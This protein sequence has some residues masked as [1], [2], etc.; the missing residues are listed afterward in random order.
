MAATKVTVRWDKMTLKDLEVD[1]SEPVELFRTQ[2]WTL[3]GVP[4]DRQTLI[5][6]GKKLKDEDSWENIRLR[7][8]SV[9]MMMG[10][11][12]QIPEA[13]KEKV[14]FVEDMEAE[15]SED[16]EHYQMVKRGLTNMGNTCYMNSTVQCL[17]QVDE[18]RGF[19][20]PLKEQSSS[21]DVR[22]KLGQSLDQLLERLDPEA[23][24]PLSFRP[25][26]FF[27]VL[28]QVH[29]A[30]GELQQGAVYKQQDA[31]ECWSLVLSQLAMA[32]SKDKNGE[33]PIDRLFGITMEETCTNTEGTDEV[34]QTNRVDR[35]LRCHIGNKTSH[36]YEGL[37]DG[38]EEE[39]TRN[40]QALGRDAL[41]KQTN[42]IKTLPP[43]L[44][45]H[46]VRFRW[47]P[48]ERVKAKILRSVSFPFTLDVL[49][50]CSDDLQ[51]QLK[52]K[53][54]DARKRRDGEIERITS[55]KGKQ[56]GDVNV[57]MQAKPSGSAQT[58]AAGAS[59]GSNAAK[60][61][62]GNEKGDVGPPLV[63]NAEI[64]VYELI[65]VLT[66]Q[67]RIAESGHYISYCKDSKDGT[68]Y[69][70]D[71]DRV[72]PQQ[73]DDI[74]KLT[75]GGDWHIAYMCLYRARNSFD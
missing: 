21:N 5:V 70:F 66:H 45:I 8:N 34:I 27:R 10:S 56:D 44:G 35:L 74:R 37:K 49:D 4:P 41:W 51:V 30:F 71:D 24:S 25:E 39:I 26:A 40:S 29:P 42:R 18:L 63:V 12:A 1:V 54:E 32:L 59:E 11:A 14:K 16:G 33:N 68:W 53:R 43:Y 9:I 65:A 48:V 31:E 15:N 19:L 22:V 62:N 3:T 67:G 36:L 20:K 60:E 64:G 7:P 75:G 72:T 38:L 2:L 50:L 28:T 6:K 69:K 58:E 61:A 17:N 55:G 46:F 23:R 57:D 13:P 73:E 52:E 47:K